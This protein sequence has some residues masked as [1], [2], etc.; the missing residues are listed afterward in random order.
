LIEIAGTTLAAVA[1]RPAM[2]T[3]LINLIWCNY[4]YLHVFS[5]VD[6]NATPGEY[7]AGV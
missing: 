2:T 7:S 6:R 1:A 5:G 3:D 4:R